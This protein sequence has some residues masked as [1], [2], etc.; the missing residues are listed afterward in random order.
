MGGGRH[1]RPAGAVADTMQRH[2]ERRRLWPG[3]QSDPSARAD[4][5]A[6]AEL[7]PPR[8]GGD[9]IGRDHQLPH[10]DEL[11]RSQHPTNTHP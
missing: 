3:R 1:P 11:D 5:H 9:N 7:P 2:L 4:A 10:R 8:N 6:G